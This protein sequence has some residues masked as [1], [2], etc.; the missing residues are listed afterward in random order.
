MH[1][2]SR[3]CHVF[4]AA[5][6]D[7]GPLAGEDRAVPDE[8]ALG[9]DVE[10]VF[11]HLVVGDQHV[12]D[13]ALAD[14]LVLAGPRHVVRV[15]DQDAP[16]HLFRLLVVFENDGYVTEPEQVDDAARDGLEGKV[17]LTQ[18]QDVTRNFEDALKSTL[19]RHMRQSYRRSGP[20]NPS[21]LV[22]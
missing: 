20:G 12:Q 21:F 6:G 18:T 8:L 1:I 17:E 3:S 2:E 22:C 15:P 19:H 10:R 5:R 14:A 4:G 13:V 9:R 16:D 11:E 7:R